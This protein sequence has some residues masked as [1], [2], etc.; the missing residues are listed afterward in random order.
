MNLIIKL[1]PT[2]LESEFIPILTRVDIL[3]FGAGVLSI[4][5]VNLGC[6]Q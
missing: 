3:V 4:Q 1:G 6:R 5:A 2:L